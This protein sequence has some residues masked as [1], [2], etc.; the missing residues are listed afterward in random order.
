M[1]LQNVGPLAVSVWFSF[2]SISKVAFSVSIIPAFAVEQ[3]LGWNGTPD[4]S[5]PDLECGC[6][7]GRI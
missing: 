3:H 7:F 6:L 1:V 5:R 2:Q 4:C